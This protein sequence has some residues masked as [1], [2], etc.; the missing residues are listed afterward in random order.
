MR[1]LII[2][3]FLSLAAHVNADEEWRPITKDSYKPNA[4]LQYWQAFSFMSDIAKEDRDLISKGYANIP[5]AKRAT[6]AKSL[7]TVARFL[8]RGADAPGCNW[9][10]DFKRDGPATLMPHLSK[11]RDLAR[12]GCLVAREQFQRG[13]HINAL[14]TVF[15]VMALARH[16]CGGDGSLISKLVEGSIM[17]MA[18][19]V[20]SQELPALP[21]ELLEGLARRFEKLPN[22][23]SL[24]DVFRSE[25]EMGMW[26]QKNWD[27]DALKNMFE[28][29]Q[30]KGMQVILADAQM[31]DAEF[32]ALNEAYDEMERLATV[33]YDK[34]EAQAQ[35]VDVKKKS[36]ILAQML[37]PAVF[38]TR[39]AV[40]I[41]KTR[42]ALIHAAVRVCLKNEVAL[43]DLPD[44]YGGKFTYTKLPTGFELTST[45]I[46]DGKPVSM[47]FGVRP[48]H[49]ALKTGPQSK[50]VAPPA[51]PERPRDF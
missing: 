40:E 10:L 9:G 33:S 35:H 44:P 12:A 24:L 39:K 15:A 22:E 45:L 25:R 41:S 8:N 48:E 30:V 14:D 5:E 26:L 16:T 3:A 31:R 28:D 19:D 34:A 4:A 11:V 51:P 17:N 6:L 36:G 29:T 47:K 20:L 7:E 37:L 2:A 13:D 49:K 50:G 27:A 18:F 46:T 32:K 23:L 38:S 43:N 1:V 42:S 21:R